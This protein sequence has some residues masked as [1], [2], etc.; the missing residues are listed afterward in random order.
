MSETYA[1]QRF[2]VVAAAADDI[3][4]YRE[5][6]RCH[7]SRRNDNVAESVEHTDIQRLGTHNLPFITAYRTDSLD[8]VVR[9]RVVVVYQ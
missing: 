5:I 4:E 2:I 8:N 1:E 6:R 3:G 7:R 9:K